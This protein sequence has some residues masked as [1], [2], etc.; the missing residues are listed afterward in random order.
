MIKYNQRVLVL[1]E[2]TKGVLNDFPQFWNEALI[3]NTYANTPNLNEM[4][5]FNEKI[6]KDFFVTE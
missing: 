3:D 2:D 5:T 4:I 6:V 1:I